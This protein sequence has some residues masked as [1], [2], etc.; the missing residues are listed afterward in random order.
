MIRSRNLGRSFG[1]KT[2]LEAV[3]LDVA[4]GD[5][6]LVTG[7]NGSGKS[8][9]LALLAG[10]LAPTRGTLEVAAERRSI[11]FVGHEPLLYQELTAAENLDL[12]G[13]LYRVQEH[14]ERSGMLLERYGIWDVRHDRVSSFSRG[15]Q[16]RLALCRAMLHEPAL[17]LLDE[18]FA[19]LDAEGVELLSDALAEPSQ[20]RTLVVSSHQS[21]RLE[22]IATLQLAL[23]VGRSR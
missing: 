12:F 17:L 22:P 13:R 2:V 10:L 20:Q 5:I 3:N 21:D 6:L 15:M 7:R 8:T 4:A 1:E 18:P 9:L 14:R 16:Q 23:E 19:A 11:G